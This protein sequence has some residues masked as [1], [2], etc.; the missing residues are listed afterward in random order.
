MDV[1]NEHLSSSMWGLVPGPV[2]SL[3]ITALHSKAHSFRQGEHFHLETL[4]PAQ[5]P[6][7]GADTDTTG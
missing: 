6:P 5:L 3:C 1:F 7:W 2:H 4:N